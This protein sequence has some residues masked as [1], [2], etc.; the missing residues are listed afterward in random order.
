MHIE[1]P[2]IYWPYT[3]A[4]VMRVKMETDTRLMMAEVAR[5][6]KYTEACLSLN[7]VAQ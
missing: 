1:N 6:A 5:E 2:T 4:L 7:F 3:S